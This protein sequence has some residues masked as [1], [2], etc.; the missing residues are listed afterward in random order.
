MESKR[1]PSFDDAGSA[2]RRLTHTP[3]L[4]FRRPVS[5]SSSASSIAS[6]EY[7]DE[8]TA[9]VYSYSSRND[10]CAL[11]KFIVWAA[12]KRNACHK[13]TP[14][15]RRECPLLRCRK[16]F[17]NHEIMLQH[18]Y[19][20]D[21]LAVGEYWCYNCIRVEKFSDAKCRKCLGHLS[22]SRRIMGMA[23]NFFNSLGHRGRNGSLLELDLE[24]EEGPPSYRVSLDVAPSPVQVAA[25]PMQVELQDTEIYEIDSYELPL[26]SILE[27]EPDATMELYTPP[28]MPPFAELESVP[29]VE[30]SLIGWQ[31]SPQPPTIAPA[32]LMNT[33]Y[34]GYSERPALQLHTS[35]LEQYRA[36][37]KAQAKSRS[38]NLAPS[39]SVRSTAS[40][41]STNSYVSTA[42]YSSAASYNIS[43][44]SAFSEGWAR[45]HGL[46]ST[47]SSPVDNL[48]TM[49][50]HKPLDAY[51]YDFNE[52]M[53]D[54]F[55]L[56]SP[57]DVPML[58]VTAPSGSAT[59]SL[60][61]FP[62][63]S[64]FYA[65]GSL[66]PGL[67]M[68]QFWTM[69]H[70]TKPQQDLPHLETNLPL[71]DD[72][73]VQRASPS[74]KSPSSRDSRISAHSLVSTA[75]EALKMH[76]EESINRL[77]DAKKNIYVDQLRDMS[78]DTV[79]LV[80]LETL[81]RILEG[82]M[83]ESPVDLICFVHLIYSFSL[84]VHEQ[85]AP[86]RGGELFSQ[87]VSYSSWLTREE[88]QGYLPIV[89][90][91]WKPPSMSDSEALGLMRKASAAS[92]F[93]SVKG[94]HPQNSLP[95]QSNDSLVLVAQFF[96]D[97]K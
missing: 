16:R 57:A 78:T 45:V 65:S 83:V 20:C 23:K 6:H 39:S 90:L 74:S 29:M 60:D 58:D 75:W 1:R 37:A 49:N 36:Q 88:Q 19:T 85:E 8:I 95:H 89:D 25:P 9:C 55:L 81:V 24:D 27:N 2:L 47:L 15:E 68:K 59:H 71:R 30:G 61:I 66:T 12:V 93:A 82:D 34:G 92:R 64:P 5:T 14:E 26:P 69:A 96:L 10:D 53:Q 35:G 18:L 43:P 13:M 11:N 51:N 3:R 46:D 84:V 33:S 76:V 17:P 31:P 41:D 80:G 38:K 62:A 32:T 56:G 72:S 28:P 94:K 7:P 87:A 54:S 67:S 44:M 42:S 91:L 70:G 77:K 86:D 50:P 48:S 4:G 73:K 22:R 79:A 63:P 21:Q 97:G 52:T 40:T